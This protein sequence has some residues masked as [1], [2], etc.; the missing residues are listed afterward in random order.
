MNT[1]E[2]EVVPK[3]VASVSTELS[4]AKD[5]ALS[6]FAPFQTPYKA[7]AEL[8]LKESAATD[9]PAAR[10]LRLD[11]V[12][13]RSSITNA[14]KSAKA[15][16]LLAG[17]VIDWYHNKGVEQLEQAEARLEDIEKAAERAEAA[18]K[19]ELKTKR[20]AELSAVSVDGQHF[21]LGE[22][23]DDAYAQ[24]LASSKLAHETKLAATAKAEADRIEAERV[25]EITR[26]KKIEDDRIERERIEAENA[27]L[28]AER[29][30]SERLAKIEREKAAAALAA[31][32]ESARVERE[33][34]AKEKAAAEKLAAEK[35]AAQEAQAKKERE[36]IEAK[37]KAERE[38]A[39]EVARVEREKRE[40]L[41]KAERERV[42]AEQKRQKEEA[43]ALARAAA[44]PD[45]EKLL[46]FASLIET[47]ELP[48]M[49]TAK[50]KDAAQA[51]IETIEQ[52]VITIR[53][54][55]SK[56]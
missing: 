7:A 13:A 42:A 3:E 26:L 33:R 53:T 22:M 27:R 11:M 50:G 45:K 46:A 40:A 29:E 38:A 20:M 6:L 47:L 9:A 56:L 10:R 30:E 49:A 15:D 2:L 16:I 52:L 1:L 44:A 55:A 8:L 37:A 18:R 34:V 14:K 12:K 23:P 31:A 4:V 19:L 36:A 51:A 17:N 39:A 35:L 43:D 24:L 41:E 32:E 5:K 21:P 54:H 48:E 25:A 28:K